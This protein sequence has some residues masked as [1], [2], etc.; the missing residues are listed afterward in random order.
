[1]RYQEV[2]GFL[3]AVASIPEVI[4]PSEWLPVIFNGQEPDFADDQQA[5]AVLDALMALLNRTVDEVNE[6]R[7]S[8][9][10][11][12]EPLPEAMANFAPDASLALWAQGFADGFDWVSESWPEE[13]PEEVSDH[14]DT[15]FMVLTFFASRE[16]AASYLD[17]MG[18]DAGSLEEMAEEMLGLLPEAMHDYVALAESYALT[19]DEAA[20]QGEVQTPVRVEKIGRNDP[21]PCG[22]GMKY[23]KCCGKE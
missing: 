6:D 5:A 1:M 2:A 3:F 8:F 12:C 4:S 21:C 23:K 17:D 16:L 13:L 9:P 11:R 18:P 7:P 20:E 19:D 10:L 22:S 15:V 14:L